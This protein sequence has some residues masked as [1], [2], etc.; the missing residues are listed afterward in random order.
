MAETAENGEA[1]GIEF[2]LLGAIAVTRDGT[3]LP[4]GGPRQ[5]AVLALLLLDANRLVPAD[6][7]V[8]TVWAGRPP[9][10]AR[11]T[12]QSYVFH[13]RR[14][15]EPGRV[16]GDGGHILIT[17]DSGYVLAVDRAHLDAAVFEEQFHAGCAAAADG[18]P[19][20]AAG[21]LRDALALWRGRALEDLADYPFTRPEATRLEE[22]RVAALEA[23]VDADLL[24]G[25][26]RALIGELQSL[27]ADYPLGERFHEQLILALY[28]SGR[29]ADA[30]AAYRRVRDQLAE[31]LGIEPGE[32]LRRL[33]QC[34]LTQERS[35][36]GHREHLPTQ[37]S[38]SHTGE[39]TA[40]SDEP[41]QHPGASQ[42]RTGSDGTARPR[43]WRHRTALAAAALPVV[44]AATV[45]IGLHQHGAQPPTLPG[46]SIGVIGGRGERVGSPL[47]AGQ[48]PDGAA[49]GA[50]AVWVVS[51]TEGTV[52]RVT[53][54]RHAVVETIHVGLAP[55]AV[56]A[57]GEDVW[58]A[59][60]GDG[61]VSRVN[62]R[63][64]T[65]VQRVEV[66]NVPVAVGSG[67][68]GVWVV[69]RGDDSVWRIDPASGTV[70]M[71]VPVGD[72]PGG[73]AAGPDAVWV[74]NT[75]D[76]T[77]SRI[78][79]TTGAVSAPTFV[80]AGPEGI[81]ATPGAVWVTN[82][83]DKSVS[84]IDNATGQVVATIPVGDGPRSVVARPDA[85]WVGEE[86]DGTLT[87]INPRSDR[88]VRRIAVGAAP[89]GLA[90]I[91][92]DVWVAVRARAAATHRGGTLTV[93]TR[94]IPEIDPTR[95][96][97]PSATSALLP[98]YDGLVR[99]RRTDGA[100]GLVLVPD[101]ATAL[102]RPTDGGRTYTFRLRA[103]VRYSTGAPVRPAD[104]RRGLERQFTAGGAAPTYYA[105]I[106][107]GRAC[108]V[109][110]AGCDLSRGVVTDDVAAT[111]TI[112]LAEPDP[113]FLYK[114]SLP[115]VVAVPS[116]VPMNVVD[117]DPLPATGP[118]QIA[119][120][121][122]GGKLVLARN[123]YFHQWSYA[124]QPAGYPDIIE[125]RRVDD[126]GAQR[127][128]ILSGHGD[129]VNLDSDGYTTRDVDR[130]ALRYP[131][132][133]R[134]ESSVGVRY[135]M[136]NTAIP[137][138]D[139]PRARRALS[140]VVDRAKLARLV[141]PPNRAPLTC[142]II[143]ADFPGHQ[144]YCPYT[145][146]A[147][148]GRWHGPDLPTARRLAAASHAEG[149]R[150]TVWT[151]A[152]P[153]ASR[154]GGELV[155]SLAELGY[156]PTLRPRPADEYFPAVFDPR[157]RVQVAVLFWGADYPSDSTFF[158]P[159]LTC[160]SR[161]SDSSGYNAAQYCSPAVDQLVSRALA[162][163]STD[164]ATARRVWMLADHSVT[165]DAPW[166][167][168]ANPRQSTLVSTRVGN[169]QAHPLFGPLLDEMWVR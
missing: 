54:A 88:V 78:D 10:G 51:T 159:V 3:G 125:W 107:G 69:N 5:R 56:T 81:A 124:A 15:L 106:V 102:P 46:N 32:P 163:Q 35:L 12:V 18:R 114:L 90:L 137:P 110:P 117:I 133:L 71:R 132:Q 7:L 161:R 141:G 101:L 22:L 92:S 40:G 157:R 58:V 55:T 153:A 16:R 25:R 79:V 6:R 72:A 68:S 147:H 28:R 168:I 82:T 123:P 66:G 29:Q 49:Y 143:P 166:I 4:L 31:E 87:R 11:T 135:A 167:P 160:G 140:Y 44:A 127:E 93:V 151:T 165:N 59:N 134:T 136:L 38:G 115:I 131:A 76:D 130:L 9:P 26:H 20:E 149:K 62:V 42:L 142:Q 43:A 41:R 17:R 57:R 138:F 148:D 65:V 34:V 83:L 2:R 112:H 145:T 37:V 121:S 8:E 164:P 19:A 14:A 48:N 162:M 154:I 13:L 47:E 21:Q 104:I 1:A 118:Y 39:M 152:D 63:S 91:G 150:V 155:T 73:V 129:L 64:N 158:V 111:V 99:L 105:G 96:Y 116:G 128:A 36:D 53:P 122:P 23:R 169:Y 61:T 113:D 98:V 85:V 126:H 100:S 33:H 24:L 84:R 45:V 97:D 89:R 95:A 30:L 60:S 52:M 86:Y 75:A 77:V 80:G 156:R 67:P 144:S 70:T 27:V 146:G 109:R 74:T 108:L 94:W 120:T 103:G 119:G 50:G 139:D